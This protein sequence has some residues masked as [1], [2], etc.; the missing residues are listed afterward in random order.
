M[1]MSRVL[2]KEI[3]TYLARKEKLLAQGEGKFVLIKGEGVVGLFESQGGALEEGYRRFR[4]EPFLVK[5]VLAVGLPAPFATR[6]I[7]V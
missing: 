4:K 2:Q 7:G 6:L 1:S 3:Q 5:Q